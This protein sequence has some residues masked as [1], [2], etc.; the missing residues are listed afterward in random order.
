MGD[1]FKASC[2]KFWIDFRRL[3]HFTLKVNITENYEVQNL[4]LRVQ[5]KHLQGNLKILWL[6]G[7]VKTYKIDFKKME[8]K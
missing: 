1:L 7:A 4:E 5:L 8:F 3:L 6:Q 2:S